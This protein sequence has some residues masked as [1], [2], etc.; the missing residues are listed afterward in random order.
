MN[1]MF[2]PTF[3]FAVLFFLA[4]MNAERRFST[5][6]SRK[7]FL[8]LAGIAALPGVLFASYYTKLLGEPIWLYR[9]RA[10]PGSELTAAGVGLIA[11]F[12]HQ[13]RHK[14][15][16]MKRQ[17]RNF[18]VPAI[19]AVVIGAPYVK[20]VIRP[21]NTKQL[22]EN[23]EDGVC[24]QSTPSTCG[25]ASAAT[26]ARALGRPVTEAELARESLSYA[27]GTENWYLARAL[28]R[29]GFAVDFCFY[30]PDAGSLPTPTIAGVKLPQGTGH[31]IALLTYDGTNYVCND[32]LT[33]RF[34]ATHAELTGGYRFTGF[35]LRIN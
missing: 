26:I 18:T 35:F 6:L 17:L 27:G 1:H 8:L 9:F 25:P 34:Q 23:W 3:F 33:G 31:F 14:H 32:P 12:T 19:L 15:P 16:W 28:R 20:P 4:G 7:L 30:E 24:I 13:V 11:G 29:R 10:M 21:L 5:N 22:R 2:W